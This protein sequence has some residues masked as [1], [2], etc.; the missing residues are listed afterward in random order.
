MNNQGFKHH[1]VNRKSVIK[2]PD[3]SKRSAEWIECE[4]C[5]AMHALFTDESANTC[6]GPKNG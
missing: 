1:W 4:H 5:E 6:P 3:G 2:H